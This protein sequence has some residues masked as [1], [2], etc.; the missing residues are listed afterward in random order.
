MNTASSSGSGT[1]PS[2]T[3]T[4]PKEDLKGVTT[5]SGIAYKGTMIPTT[6][7]PTKVVERETE[8]TT[9]TVPPTNNGST[10]DVMRLQ[11][12]YTKIMQRALLKSIYLNMRRKHIN[13]FING[14][15]NEFKKQT[16]NTLNRVETFETFDALD[17]VMSGYGPGYDVPSVG[18]PSA[19]YYSQITGLYL[20]VFQKCSEFCG[21]KSQ[22]Q[23]STTFRVINR[24]EDAQLYL[25]MYRKYSRVSRK[26]PCV[27]QGM[28]LRVEFQK[29]GLLH[30]HTLLWVDSASKIRIA[31]D[32]DRFIL[33]ELP[34]PRID[35]EGY[36]VVLELMIHGPCGAVSLKAPCMKGDK[37]S[38]KF[39]KKF[40]QKTFFD[41]NGHVHYQRRDTSVSAKRNEFHLDNSYVVSYNRDL[42][43][44]FQ[45]HINMEYC[46]WSM[47]IK[48]LFKYISKGTDKVFVRVARPTGESL[49]STTPS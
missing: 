29:R 17:N 20:D 32:V 41:E 47:L 24:I 2:N 25:D 16:G 45:A 46:G 35:P 42:L 12:F 14:N 22:R 10:K 38:K 8:V 11:Q 27:Q 3:I 34:D 49:T 18:P 44:A 7:S 4:N 9:D 23:C 31:E 30:C 36:N 39:P 6:P 28:A 33:A 43:L 26:I 13:E 48:Y 21:V 5:R 37:C 19:S 1:L 40:N 15:F